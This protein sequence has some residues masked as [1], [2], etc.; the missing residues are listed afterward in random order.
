MQEL[1]FF[2]AKFYR[3]LCKSLRKP[4]A[5]RL[6]KHVRD[7]LG[8]GATSSPLSF[9]SSLSPTFVHSLFPI[10]SFSPFFLPC[11]A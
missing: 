10:F 9:F 5:V 3:L 1:D 11:H 4:V 2:F 7:L 6:T 8:S